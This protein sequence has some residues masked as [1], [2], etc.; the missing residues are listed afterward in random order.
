MQAEP[1]PVLMP[2][3][4]QVTVEAS[5]RTDRDTAGE[6]ERLAAVLAACGSIRAAARMLG[7]GES[8]LR[9]RLKRQ[10]IGAPSKRGRKAGAAAAA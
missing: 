9:G 1:V 4:A 10:G 5:A 8:T 7:V 2:A 3:A 6:R